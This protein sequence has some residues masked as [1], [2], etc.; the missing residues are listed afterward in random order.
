MDHQTIPHYIARNVL[1]ADPQG[2]RCKQWSS[3]LDL[4]LLSSKHL[5]DLPPKD[6]DKGSRRPGSLWWHLRNIQQRTPRNGHQP[7]CGHTCTPL[8]PGRMYLSDHCKSREDICRR[9]HCDLTPCRSLTD[10]AHSDVP[11]SLVDKNI[12]PPSP[13]AS[14]GN[15]EQPSQAP[16]GRD[17]R[18]LRQHNCLAL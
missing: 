13:L 7:C 6:T 17:S 4:H 15:L 18:G 2:T 14:L 10:S 11:R 5:A 1:P 12:A 8:F 9:D 16:P 3:L